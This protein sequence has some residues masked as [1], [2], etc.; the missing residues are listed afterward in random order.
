VKAVDRI[1]VV[2]DDE[3]IRTM[4]CLI[5]ELQGFRPVPSYDGLD[6][7]RILAEEEP[8][9]LILLDIM[10]P[11]MGGEEL[12]SALL[13]SSRLSTIPVVVMSGDNQSREKAERSGARGCLVKPIDLDVLLRT[14]Q[15][16][17]SVSG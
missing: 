3:D 1:L 16:F 4:V 9:S 12:M 7:L 11:R 6:A 14:V 5:L 15:Q 10:M 8:P 17:T 2:E 13:A